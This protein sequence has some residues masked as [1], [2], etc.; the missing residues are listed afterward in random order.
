MD[1]AQNGLTLGG[2]QSRKLA[3]SEWAGERWWLLLCVLCVLLL[4]WWLVLCAVV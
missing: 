2:R 1:F 3:L 4:L